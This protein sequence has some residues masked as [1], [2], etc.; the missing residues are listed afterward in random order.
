MQLQTTR[1]PVFAKVAVGVDH[2]M[3]IK[4]FDLGALVFVLNHSILREFFARYIEF[5]NAGGPTQC[6]CASSKAA[7]NLLESCRLNAKE[8]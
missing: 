7:A 8:R 3:I 2:E 1:R 5:D 4:E 6:R